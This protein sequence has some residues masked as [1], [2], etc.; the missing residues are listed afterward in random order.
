MKLLALIALLGPACGG[1]SNSYAT[2]CVSACTPA[3]SCA[4]MDASKCNTDCEASTSGTS[5]ACAQCI[6]SDTSW[7]ETHGTAGTMC[8]GYAVGSAASMHCAP[9][10][11]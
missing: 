7:R 9:L 6:I 8:A 4:G 11:K 2:L 1:S 5:T 10:C 3:G